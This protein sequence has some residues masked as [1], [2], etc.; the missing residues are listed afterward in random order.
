[1]AHTEI[2]RKE[3][4]AKLNNIDQTDWIKATQKLGLNVIKCNRGT[5]HTH[6]VRN[7]KVKDIDDVRGLI[8]VL[9]KNLYKQANRAIFNRLLDFGLLEDDV[10]K[11][12]KML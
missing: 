1:M 3:L 8:V 2:K 10:W 11:A 7:P 4:W 9:Q 12:L 5:S 6:S